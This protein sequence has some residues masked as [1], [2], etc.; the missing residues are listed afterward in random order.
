MPGLFVFIASP[1]G[2]TTIGRSAQIQGSVSGAGSGALQHVE[3]QFGTSGPVIVLPAPAPRAS[4]WGWQGLIP[5]N[6]RPG[7]SFRITVRAKGVIQTKPYPEPEYTD[8]DGEAVLD[9]VLENIV[10]VLTVEAFQSPVAVET[11]PMSFTLAGTVSEGNGPP[12]AVPRLRVQVGG[13][14]LQEVPV[15]AGR[16]RLA[17]SLPP[18]DHP[19][20]VQ[21]SDDFDSVASV[22]RTLTVLRYVRPAN[23]DPRSR[24][25]QAGAPTTASITAW[26]RLEP[27]CTDTTLASSTGARLFDPLWMLTRQWQLG[28]FQGEDAG[29]PVQARVRA[30]SASLS[31]SHLGTLAANTCGS[32]YSPD[33]MPLEVLTQRRRM[34]PAGPDE[35]RMVPLAIEAGQLFLRRLEA[36]ATGR[37]YRA[38]FL[39]RYALLP[40]PVGAPADPATLRLFQTMTGRAPDA[41]R[42][43]ESL[44]ASSSP[45]FAFD[46][47]LGI[48][49]AD[50][51][52][53]RSLCVAWLSW[54]DSLCSEPSAGSADAWWP[55]RLEYG[56]SVA[57]RLGAESN[58]GIT[59]TATAF[60][61]GRLDWSS[62][63]V[64][65]QF[66]IDSVGDSNF[67]AVTETSIPAPVTS[68]GAP[69]PRFWELEN[70][71]VAYGLL[72]AGPTDQA[73]LMMIEYAGSYG[74]DWFVAPLTLKAGTVTRIDSLVVTDTFGI[75][76]L[77]RPIGDPALPAPHFSMWQSA[78]ASPGTQADGTPAF[79]RF[80]LPPTLG[81]CL[82]GPPL[83][84]V[85]LLRDEMAN[86][87]WGIEQLLEGPLEQ[88]LPQKSERSDLPDVPASPAPLYRLS[89]LAPDHWIPLLPSWV[90]VGG[91][92]SSR[93]QR[94][95]MRSPDGSMFEQH[96]RSDALSASS[97]LQLYDEEVPREGAR[98]TKRRRMVRWMDGSSWLWTAF[99]R[100]VG[101]GEGSSRLRFDWLDDQVE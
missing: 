95:V 59:F 37:K 67:T 48:A 66:Q 35:A 39:S 41:R 71:Q 26:T 49:P 87:A 7:Q 58:A 14:A 6:V 51:A 57:A 38:A 56:L 100:D 25:T 8:V 61:G 65:A 91:E 88:A 12:Y 89:S 21:A 23:A 60:D 77:L 13:Q 9:V 30:T 92:R 46:A 74:N 93:L 79:N 20:T 45:A 10:P 18:G 101:R 85:L 75:R 43:V 54:Y 63:D 50:V 27:Q 69:A 96:A 84:D 32:P 16:W 76:S 24:T 22:S 97:A 19:I 62:F 2:G 82:E 17:L 36:H 64:N 80:F 99:R 55:E 81:P 42:L 34:R 1:V 44:R 53:V 98:L 5:N 3:V 11:L 70:A 47:A 31:R 73:Q 78:I 68:R 83:E 72:G 86:M 33:V 4:T 15:D 40:L 29:T 28:E 94:G 90:N 52:A